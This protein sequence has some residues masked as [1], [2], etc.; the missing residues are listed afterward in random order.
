MCHESAIF[1]KVHRDECV[2]NHLVHSAVGN[3]DL[4]AL[5]T[6][7]EPTTA[8]VEAMKRKFNH[9]RSLVVRMCAESIEPDESNEGSAYMRRGRR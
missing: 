4:A 6:I 2:C 5:Q 3:E 9:L 8:Q 7:D 1:S